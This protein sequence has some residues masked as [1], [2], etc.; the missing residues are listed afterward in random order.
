MNG[1]LWRFTAVTIALTLAGTSAAQDATSS[2][3][4]AAWTMQP[5]EPAA[6]E[7]R[8]VKWGEPVFTQPVALAEAAI[9]T[10]DS[11]VE[12]PGMPLAKTPVTL[13]LAKGARFYRVATA[14]PGHRAYCGGDSG[15]KAATAMIKLESRLC[16]V[17][18][19]GDGVF[20][21]LMLGTLSRPPSG[22]GVFGGVAFEL[23]RLL[24]AGDAGFQPM[25]LSADP[26]HRIAVRFTTSRPDT[27][28]FSVGPV[29]MREKQ[30]VAAGLMLVGAEGK[31]RVTTLF[32][33]AVDGP[34]TD[35]YPKMLAKEPQFKHLRPIQ[36]DRLPA[37]VDLGGASLIVKAIDAEGA[38][39]EIVRDF[40]DAPVPVA[41]AGLILS[42]AQ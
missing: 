38:Q 31:G 7:V 15:Y 37:T 22:P 25:V 36:L 29:L 28:L 11:D 14:D 20:D 18:E 39:I 10:D 26:R 3:R 32:D 34:A 41:L 1:S 5:L 8:R 40:G 12:L 16:L 21:Q 23:V 24:F 27:R 4:K 30:A 2:W 35:R 17:D 6:R 33:P 19:G 9:L 42:D 13:R